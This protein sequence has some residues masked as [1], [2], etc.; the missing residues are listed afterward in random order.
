V[1]EGYRDPRES[2]VLP[3]VTLTGDEFL[4]IHALFGELIPGS[5]RAHYLSRVPRGYPSPD[6]PN[7]SSIMAKGQ[8]LIETCERMGVA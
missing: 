1:V 6:C 3:D 2:V 7:C 4:H 5:P 8:A